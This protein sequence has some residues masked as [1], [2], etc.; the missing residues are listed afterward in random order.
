[1]PAQPCRYI[2]FHWMDPETE[3]YKDLSMREPQGF[4]DIGE[5]VT[6]HITNKTIHGTVRVR[7]WD[8]YDL[9]KTRHFPT[10]EWG[11]SIFL[12]PVT[13]TNKTAGSHTVNLEAIEAQ[14]KKD[15]D[16]E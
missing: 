16:S 14:I 7:A 3:D 13:V 6:L 1:M 15:L 10:D 11:L 8:Y 12:S 9:E 4:P 5:K 2:I